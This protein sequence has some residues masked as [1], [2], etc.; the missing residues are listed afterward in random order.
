MKYLFKTIFRNFTRR[1][2]T[3]LI[4]LIGLAVSFSLVIILSVYCYSELSTDRYHKNGDRVYMYIPSAEMIYTPGILKETIEK[5]VPGVESAIRMVGT[6]E[7]PVFQ[8][9]NGNPVTSHLLFADDGF[10]KLFSY[11]FIEG[12]PQSVFKDPMTVVITKKLSKQLFGSAE[13]MGK[14]IKLNN[15]KELTVCAIIEEPET[16]SCLSLSA[17]SSMATQKIVQGESGEF[18]E[19]GWCD[20]QTFLLLNN[21]IKPVDAGKII[22]NVIPAD[23]KKDYKNASLVPLKKI[24]FS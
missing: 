10:F 2:V 7:P 9:E 16:N 5:K 13:S 21:G 24:Y 18:T 12:D 15:N 1:P 11:T 3:N 4:N 23:Y 22:L 6:W 20:F 8:A 17:V 14:V 19:W